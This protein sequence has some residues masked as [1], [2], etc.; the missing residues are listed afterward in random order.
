MR[1]VIKLNP[2]QMSL[3][4]I[5]IKRH[6]EDR[7][8]RPVVYQ[9]AIGAELYARLLEGV[10]KRFIDEFLNSMLDIGLESWRKMVIE[11]NFEGKEDI[12]NE[13]VEMAC[14]GEHEGE[15]VH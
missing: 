12:V 3:L 15:T 1:D 5:G 6:L 4:L 9:I 8:D 14:E 13:L 2:I 11:E 7:K 10:P